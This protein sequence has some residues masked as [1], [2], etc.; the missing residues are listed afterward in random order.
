MKH[1]LLLLL[2]TLMALSCKKK[3]LADFE[4]KGEVLNLNGTL[5][6]LEQNGQVMDSTVVK[7]NQFSLHGVL[8][9]NRLCQVVFKSDKPILKNKQK[10]NW[11]HAVDIFVEDGAFYRFKANSPDEILYNTYKITTTSAGQKEFDAYRASKKTEY[12]VLKSHLSDLTLKQDSALVQKNDEAYTRYTDSIRLYEKAL[13]LLNLKH[14]HRAIAGKPNSYL[15]LYLLSEAPDIHKNKGFYQYIH[16]KLEKKYL[17]HPYGVTFTKRLARA[18]RMDSEPVRLDIEA[19]N[20]YKKPFKYSDFAESKLLILDLWATWCAPCL[21]EIPSALKLQKTFARD[22]KVSY[23][24]LSYDFNVNAWAAQSQTLGLDNSY[25]LVEK[26]K[27]VLDEALDI[28][29]IPRYIILNNRGDVLVTDA[30]SP[31][32]PKLKELVQS[33][34]QMEGR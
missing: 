28:P 7:N 30:P 25:L 2:V 13:R 5:V 31:A 11:L 33:L 34:L 16:Q 32:S 29:T 19:V 27:E 15:S 18:G 17:E 20:P 21:Q 8:W 24:F 6:L 14:I 4:I 9:D 23:V 26:Y 1:I 12:E 22:K 3:G 10:V